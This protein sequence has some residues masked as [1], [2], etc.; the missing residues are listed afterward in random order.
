[1]LFLYY[2]VI[3]A[4]NIYEYKKENN[5]LTVADK[6]IFKMAEKLLFDELAYVLEINSNDVGE[7]L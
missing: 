6:E 3:L 4:R 1:M 5:N 7:Y 2:I